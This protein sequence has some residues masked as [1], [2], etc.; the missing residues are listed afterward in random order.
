[1]GGAHFDAQRFADETFELGHVA[2]G[3][4]EFQ[5]RVAGRAKLQEAVIAPIVHFQPRHGL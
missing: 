3:G 4:P 2:C 1:M 5:F